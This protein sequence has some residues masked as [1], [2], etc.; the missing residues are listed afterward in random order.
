MLS[1]LDFLSIENLKWNEVILNDPPYPLPDTCYNYGN[2]DEECSRMIQS[3]S[4]ERTNRC[5]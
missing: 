4:P 3:K 5:Y 1:Q 2:L